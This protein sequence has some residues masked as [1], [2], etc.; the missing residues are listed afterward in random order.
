MITTL[1]VMT[2]RPKD[3]YDVD[4][5]ATSTEVTRSKLTRKQLKRTLI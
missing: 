4:G 3:D 1:M 2:I 5:D